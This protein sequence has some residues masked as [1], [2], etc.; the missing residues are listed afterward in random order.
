MSRER[1]KITIRRTVIQGL[2]AGLLALALSGSAAALPP[3]VVQTEAGPIDG[4]PVQTWTYPS[5]GLKVKGLL[6]LPR[7]P[8]KR[9]LVLFNHDG[10]DGISEAHRRAC[11]RLARAGYAVFAP[12]YRGEEGSEGTIEVAAG[13]V[14]DVLNV[15]PFLAR[16]PGIDGR[17][18]AFLGASHGA[19]I[20]VL[21]AA[22][23]PKVKAVVEAYG[24]MD[25]R[26]WWFHL[27]RTGQLGE[28]ELTRRVYGNGPEDRP[29]A[30]ASRDALGVVSGLKAPVLI[31]QGGRDELVPPEQALT[32][33]AALDRS[34]IPATLKL[35]PHCPHSFLVYGPYRADGVDA[36]ERAE[37]ELAWRDLLAFLDK[38]LGSPRTGR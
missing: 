30:F 28:D 14:R 36:V 2:A 10:V 4:V 11:A 21:A 23:Y 15:L 29:P 1:K 25:I 33:K 18:V 31:L 12:A 8:E 27:K 7:S 19:L 6:F 35:Y 9:P 38:H 37:T 32:F 16:V 24:V 3:E 17:R 26:A 20:S 5:D 34:G 13:E 22:R